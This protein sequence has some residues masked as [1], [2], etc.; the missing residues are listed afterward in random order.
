M[1]STQAEITIRIFTKKEGAIFGKH[2]CFYA[3]IDKQKAIEIFKRL[4][5]ELTDLEQ[6]GE[7]I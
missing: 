6:L 3:I 7:S 2:N 5:H 4:E 1:K